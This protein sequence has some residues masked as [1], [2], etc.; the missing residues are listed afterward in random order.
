MHRLREARQSL[1][2]FIVNGCLCSTTIPYREW[3]A[4]S[5]GLICLALSCGL[6]E[7]ALLLFLLNWDEA[8]N[9]E[10]T[11]VWPEGHGAKWAM[12][13]MRCDLLKVRDLDSIIT[14]F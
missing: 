9:I 8:S 4:W 14:S 3:K 10:V 1:A 6:S 7:R 5:L 11:L 13:F 2:S 12:P